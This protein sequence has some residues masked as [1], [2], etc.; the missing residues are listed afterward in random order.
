MLFVGRFNAS[1]SDYESQKSVALEQLPYLHLSI[2]ITL[3]FFCL[4]LNRKLLIQLDEFN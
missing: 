3:I 1:L 4:F 2:F